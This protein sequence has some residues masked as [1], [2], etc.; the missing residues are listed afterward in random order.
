MLLPLLGYKLAGKIEFSGWILILKS[1]KDDEILES[2]FAA[3]ATK[4]LRSDSFS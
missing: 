2:N 4:M 1:A 3:N